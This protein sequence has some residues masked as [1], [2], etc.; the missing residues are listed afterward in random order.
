[1][2]MMMPM[3]MNSDGSF[4][5]PCPQQFMPIPMASMGTHLFNNMMMMM[6]QPPHVATLPITEQQT[7]HSDV[8]NQEQDA[9]PRENSPDCEGEALKSEISVEH[10]SVDSKLGANSS[11]LTS[12][13]R[14]TTQGDNVE[15]TTPCVDSKIDIVKSS[16]LL[17]D[18]TQEINGIELSIGKISPELVF[19]NLAKDKLS[20]FESPLQPQETNQEA[21]PSD[22]KASELSKSYLNCA[23]VKQGSS[24]ETTLQ[25]LSSSLS[26]IKSV[27]SDSPESPATN[28][29]NSEQKLFPSPATPSP[30][31]VSMQPTFSGKDFKQ[32]IATTE[33]PKSDT[34]IKEKDVANKEGCVESHRLS[35]ATQALAS[36]LLG[37]SK[38]V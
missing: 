19:T 6:H 2:V 23:E 1:M 18:K 14:G 10:S 28:I 3:L 27:G 21:E 4:D 11:N 24:C 38:S 33:E 30:D 26:L 16:G 22:H 5:Q 25:V 36:T 31:T 34:R 8:Q 7:K 9:T 15:Y 13:L 12:A 29:P 37:L 20:D 35:Q 32:S 17:E